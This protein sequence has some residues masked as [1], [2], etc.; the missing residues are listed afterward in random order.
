MPVNAP[1]LYSILT[2]DILLEGVSDEVFNTNSLPEVGLHQSGEGPTT[3]EEIHFIDYSL[4]IIIFT[5]TL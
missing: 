2:K 4:L 3:K 5:I 1:I